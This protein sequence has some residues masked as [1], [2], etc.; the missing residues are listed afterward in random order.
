[1][2]LGEITI[3]DE[4]VVLQVEFEDIEH[5]LGYCIDHEIKISPKFIDRGG[6]ERA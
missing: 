6:C 2:I 1:M 3:E 5:A 4:K